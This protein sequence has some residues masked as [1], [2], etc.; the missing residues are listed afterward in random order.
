VRLRHIIHVCDMGHSYVK[1]DSS[2]HI[3]GRVRLDESLLIDEGDVTHGCG[4]HDSWMW[5]P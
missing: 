4:C 5:V 3:Q 1:R 2:I